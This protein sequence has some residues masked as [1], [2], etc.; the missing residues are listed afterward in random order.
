MPDT[1]K[2]RGAHPQDEALFAPE[3][4]P[5]LQQAVADVS[6]LL[7]RGY[8]DNAVRQL[9]GDRYQLKDRQRIAVF[10]AA[11]SEQ[12]LVTRHQSRQEPEVCRGAALIVDGYNLLITLESA[13]GGG[14]LLA[15]RDGCYRDLASLHG[16]YR[17]VE[18]TMPALRLAGKG[19]ADLEV[20]SVLWLFDAPVS[21]SGRLRALTLDLARQ[22]GWPWQAELAT[23]VDRRLSD[24]DNLVVTSDS[25][26]LDR[27]RQW[28][29]LARHLIEKNVK[30]AWVLD[31]ALKSENH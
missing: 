9:V 25:H 10:R 4:I 23:D 8:S 28:T 15:C 22:E 16:T 7:T 18:E 19:L 13:L 20:A 11:C 17:T 30:H 6:W 24:A 1:R 2:H 29:N 14:V 27:A 12:S 5:V 3:R 26:V 31:L 21:N